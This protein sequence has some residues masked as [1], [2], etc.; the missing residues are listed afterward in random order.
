LSVY[1]HSWESKNNPTQAPPPKLPEH[2]YI[3]IDRDILDDLVQHK[4]ECQKELLPTPESPPARA[5]LDPGSLTCGDCREV[6][7]NLVCVEDKCQCRQNMIWNARLKQCDLF[8]N[9]DCQD[10]RRVERDE[11]KDEADLILGRSP[12]SPPPLLDDDKLRNVYCSILDGKWEAYLNLVRGGPKPGLFE[13]PRAFL[14]IGSVFGFL[15]FFGVIHR[16]FYLYIRSF[17][18]RWIMRN[19]TTM[20]TQLASLTMQSGREAMDLQ[21]ERRD[22][23]RANMMQLQSSM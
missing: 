11:Y 13:G 1:E 15:V 8:H 16:W 18:P 5:V 7:T 6:D 3:D 9:V 22:E 12:K 20:R 21:E 23:A 17:D 19:S 14:L 4:P 2:C 10:A